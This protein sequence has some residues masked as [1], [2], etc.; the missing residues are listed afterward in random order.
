MDGS[1][2]TQSSSSWHSIVVYIA[3]VF[4]LGAIFYVPWVLSSYGLFPVEPIALLVI[5]GGVS[6]TIAAAAAMRSQ[7]RGAG[8]RKLFSAAAGQEV[9]KTALALSLLLPLV[10]F[11]GAVTLYLLTGGVY[12]LAMDDL[13]P[14]V[15]MLCV[16]ALVSVWEEIGWR[17]FAQPELQRRY[18]ALVSS[19]IVG[20]I[21]ALWHW[22]HFAVFGSQMP[23]VYGSYVV[24]V[25]QTVVVSVIY[26]ALYNWGKGNVVA[27]TLFHGGFNALGGI[28]MQTAGSAVPIPFMIVVELVIIVVLAGAF[29]IDS[30]SRGVRVKG[31]DTSAGSSS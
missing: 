4:A 8:V 2:R 17:G 28:L 24:F 31:I 21:W 18:S 7:N 30:L 10:V 13:L 25:S 19:L 14:Y 26:G 11:Y 20:L 5:L 29:G 3:V 15:P 27:P 12:A 22:P 9:D 1:T 23:D 6:P 16:A